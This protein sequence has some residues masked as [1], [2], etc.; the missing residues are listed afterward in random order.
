[1][2]QKLL[3]YFAIKYVSAYL[4]PGGIYK[5]CVGIVSTVTQ[6]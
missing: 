1:M 5:M 2:V 3:P 4:G 6:K